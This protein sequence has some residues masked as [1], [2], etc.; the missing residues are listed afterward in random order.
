[1]RLSFMVG[2]SHPPPA[3]TLEKVK[4]WHCRCLL[5]LHTLD[6]LEIF[7]P[8]GK[9]NEKISGLLHDVVMLL[10]GLHSE[11]ALLNQAHSSSPSH[12]APRIIRYWPGN[13]KRDC[14]SYILSQLCPSYQ[15]TPLYFKGYTESSSFTNF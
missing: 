11:V 6:T 2:I 12:R 13:P 14:Q 1:M 4:E 9:E 3:L 15:F 10:L 7:Y 5:N 8:C